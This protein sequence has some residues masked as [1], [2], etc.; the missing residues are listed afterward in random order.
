MLIHHYP[1]AQSRSQD[2][3]DLVASCQYFI[4][5]CHDDILADWQIAQSAHGLNRR[6]S[7]VFDFGHDDQQVEVAVRSRIAPRP[8]AKEDNLVRVDFTGQSP[9]C[10]G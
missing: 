5:G 10:I 7:L 3:A 1:F 4:G 2:K 6:L 9:D 8:R